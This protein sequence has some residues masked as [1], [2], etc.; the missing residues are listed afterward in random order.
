MAEGISIMKS[1]SNSNRFF[2]FETRWIKIEN[3][4]CIEKKKNHHLG[5][6]RL[7]CIYFGECLEFCSKG[8]TDPMMITIRIKKNKRQFNAESKNATINRKLFDYILQN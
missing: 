1:R 6:S 4:S 3:K 8:K 5:R 7:P 2:A